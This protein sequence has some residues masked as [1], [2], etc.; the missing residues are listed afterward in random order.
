MSRRDLELRDRRRSQTAATVEI[1]ASAVSVTGARVPSMRAR[2]SGPAISLMGLW[3]PVTLHGAA[4]I[5]TVAAV[6]TAGDLA[7]QD[8]RRSSAATV[9]LRG[10]RSA[11]SPVG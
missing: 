5:S 11:K 7:I 8:P 9:L 6:W 10:A 3:P 4:V 2:I 1:T